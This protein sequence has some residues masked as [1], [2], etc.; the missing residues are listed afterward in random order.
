[1]FFNLQSLPEIVLLA[2]DATIKATVDLSRV[3]LDLD[4]LAAAHPDLLTVVPAASSTGR[5]SVT[6]AI[7]SA[8][9]LALQPKRTPPAVA[10]GVSVLH[11]IILSVS[12]SLSISLSLSLTH[13]FFS[14]L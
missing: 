10:A 7:A 9:G 12:L 1:V 4:T 5:G 6:A 11:S 13:S 3:S 14:S 2:V 8:G